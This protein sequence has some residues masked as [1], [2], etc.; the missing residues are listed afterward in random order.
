MRP[1]VGVVSRSTARPRVDLPEPDSPTRP[2]TSRRL[3]EKDTSSTARTCW[4]RRA[5]KLPPTAY[6]CER[7][8]TSR[9]AEEAEPDRSLILASL[10]SRFLLCNSAP[11]MAADEMV[12]GHLLD[13]GNRNVA[14]SSL[15]IVAA[16]VEGAA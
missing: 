1:L 10:I 15:G 6:H 7:P 11:A 13:L 2:S 3:S 9:T 16:R 14:Q 5:K 4:R 8:C 12:G